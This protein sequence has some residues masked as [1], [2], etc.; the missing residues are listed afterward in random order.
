MISTPFTD[1]FGVDHPIVCGGMTGVGTAELIS[2]V[3]E[4]GALGFLTALTQPTPE[5]LSREIARCREMTDKPF[6]VNLTILPTLKPVPYAEYRAAVIESGVTVVET[7]GSNPAEHVAA[8]KSAGV[9]VIHKAVA[10]RH[11][12]KA[13]G[14]GVDAVSIDGFE[15]AGHPGEED[16]PGLVLVPAA[17]RRLDIPVIASGGFAT[18]SGLAAAL[19]LGACAINMGTRFVASAEAPVHP[20]VKEQIVANDE[21]AT[22]LV[23]REFGN[24]GRVARNAISEEIVTRSRRPGAV[25]EDVA[26]LA[27]GVR[28]RTRVLQEG[29]MDDGL[30]W[31]GQAQGL[32][33][34][35]ATCD[36]IVS[37]IVADAEKIIGRLADLR[38]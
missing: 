8:F 12:L 38:G 25:F 32:I 10:V 6:G 17:V 11:A 1:L 31:A 22:Q 16:I 34:S 3:A 28:G 27:S 37:G 30:W 4:A 24:T 21:R 29:H 33:E 23:F 15:C 13:Q 18:G 14:L 7:A 20:N 35:V 5:A 36:E 2:A 9:K 19:A 26:E